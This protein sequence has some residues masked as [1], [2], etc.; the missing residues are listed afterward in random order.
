VVES[1]K[2]VTGGVTYNWFIH[3]SVRSYMHAPL[4]L[5]FKGPLPTTG[6]L[7][8][9]NMRLKSQL[10]ATNQL[11]FIPAWCLRSLADQQPLFSFSITLGN[12]EII[13]KIFF[14]RAAEE[15][16]HVFLPLRVFKEAN[17]FYSFVSSAT[18]ETNEKAP[19]PCSFLIHESERE[20]VERSISSR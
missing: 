15:G 19:R 4:P 13:T 10:Q 7:A 11:E 1:T 12:C 18:N 17:P 6:R 3:R 14:Y 5:G 8:W 20:K 16:E 9:S 2:V